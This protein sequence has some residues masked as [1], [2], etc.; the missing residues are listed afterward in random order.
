M[1]NQ[2]LARKWRPKNFDSIVGQEFAIQAIKNSIQNERIHH[3]YLFSGTRGVGKT[4]IARIFAKCLNC[5]TGVTDTPCCECSSCLEIDQSKAIDVIEL[6]A[7]SNTQ[8]DNM[9]ELM[10]N[11]N[12]QPTSSP[13]KVFIIDEVHMLSKSSFNAMLKTLEEPPAHVIFIL[14]TTDPEK[15]PVTVVS[16][17]LHFNLMQMTNEELIGQL[18]KIFDEE[19]INYDE[20]AVD[21]IAQFAEGSMRDALS[22]ADRVINYTNGE[23]ISEKLQTI[24]GIISKDT[25]TDLIE[26][27]VNNK[28]EVVQSILSTI[29]TANLSYENILKTL[30]ERFYDISVEQTFNE[31]PD[32][33][34]SMADVIDPKLLQTLYQI[35]IHGLKDLPLAPNPYVGFVM[36]VIRLMNFMPNNNPNN[37]SLEPNKETQPNSIKKS[38]ST[39]EPEKKNLTSDDSYIKINPNNWRQVVEQLKHGMAKTLAQNCEINSFSDQQLY[40][41]VDDKFKHLNNDKYINILESS[42][43]ELTGERVRVFIQE[44]ETTQTPAHEKS[45]EDSEALK[46][47]T[48]SIKSDQNLEKILNEFEGQIIEETIKPINH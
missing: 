45:L 43:L 38:N 1:K 13:Y 15:I 3:A 18:K 46:H 44:A 47:A 24:L 11:A 31:N 9:R 16:R 12:Y 29:K 4:T 14:A 6:D 22:L 27:I 2:A 40:L 5:Q 20:P 10:E 30:S 35:T 39:E 17:C 37:M 8:V 23:V 41:A 33:K 28:K 34:K 42:L 25:T 26:A 48:N 21:M 36:T 32:R 19:K 7:A